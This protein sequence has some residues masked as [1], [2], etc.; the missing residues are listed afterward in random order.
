LKLH[1]PEID[2][3]GETPDLRG[4]AGAPGIASTKLATL[5][6]VREHSEGSPVE[7]WLNRSGRVVVR[8]FNECGNNYTE[9]DLFDLLSWAEGARVGEIEY[10]GG[11]IA[12]LSSAER[13]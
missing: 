1:T 5:V 9:V 6:G 12:A 2:W 11:W 8:A 7:L 3:D 10:G 13:D 4:E